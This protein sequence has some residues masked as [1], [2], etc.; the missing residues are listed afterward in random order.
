MANS[1]TDLRQKLA[2]DDFQAFKSLISCLVFII[3][4][5]IYIVKYFLKNI[6]YSQKIENHNFPHRPY[7]ILLSM[8][9]ANAFY[10]SNRKVNQNRNY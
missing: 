7:I 6:L 1:M 8:F 4:R 2:F 10:P 9:K 5:Y 3:Y